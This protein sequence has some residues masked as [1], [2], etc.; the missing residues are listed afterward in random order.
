MIGY[1]MFSNRQIFENKVIPINSTFEQKRYGHII[2]D[3][4]TKV[5]PGTPFII[6]LVIEI[7]VIFLPYGYY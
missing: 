6:I 3:S 4:F 2:L 5:S 7:I 1:W